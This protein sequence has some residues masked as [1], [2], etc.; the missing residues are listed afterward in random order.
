MQGENK[1]MKEKIVKTLSAMLLVAAMTWPSQAEAASLHLTWTDTSGAD[2]FKI[3]RFIG[4]SYAEIAIVGA[5]VQSYADSD[6]MGGTIYCYRVKAFNSEGDSDYSEEVCDTALDGDTPTVPDAA[7]LVSPSGTIT[8]PTPTYTW[9]AVS[10][11]TWYY[12]VVVEDV[13]VIA[14]WYTASEA[15]CASGTNTCS[16]TPS[17][18][19]SAGSA[20][21]WIWTWNPAGW[22]PGSIPMSLVVQ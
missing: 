9:N 7:S 6:L 5:D 2:G 3:E 8:T 18:A 14:Q 16:V 4:S 12:L 19:L 13:A 15:G 17:T 20:Q 1:V 21:W 10:G 11:A 22:G